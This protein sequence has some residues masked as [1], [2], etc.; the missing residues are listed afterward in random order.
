[1]LDLKEVYM[2]NTKAKTK[3]KK[4]KGIN[5]KDLKPDKAQVARINSIYAWLEGSKHS[6]F[7]SD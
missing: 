1:M 4:I 3:L 5:G 6:T 2:K 7:R